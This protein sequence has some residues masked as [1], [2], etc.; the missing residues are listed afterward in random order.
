MPHP[1]WTAFWCVFLEEVLAWENE[2]EK[3]DEQKGNCCREKLLKQTFKAHFCFGLGLRCSCLLVFS[4]PKKSLGAGRAVG[5]VPG[6]V[7]EQCSCGCVL[8]QL[9]SDLCWGGWLKGAEM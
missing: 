3:C 1:A 7:R 8:Q 5:S 4:Q 2:A 9:S 6:S